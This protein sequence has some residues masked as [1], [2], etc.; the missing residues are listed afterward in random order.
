[1]DLGIA[2]RFRDGS[3]LPGLRRPRSIPTANLKGVPEEAHGGV[4]PSTRVALNGQ[5]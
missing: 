5:V 2:T 3:P 1:M 4:T